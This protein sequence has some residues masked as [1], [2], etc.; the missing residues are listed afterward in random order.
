MCR[1]LGWVARDGLSLRDVLGEESFVAFAQLSR[2][3]ADGWGLAYATGE[4]LEV[5][6]STTNA[7]SDP[8][9]AKVAT[10][11]SSRAGLAHLRWASPGLPVELC[12]AHPFRY[13]DGVGDWAFAHNGGVYPFERVG[14]LL[15]DEWRARLTGTT[16]SEHYFL[17]L[18]AEM[19]ESGDDLPT[20]LPRVLRRI[21]EHYTPS[22]LNAMI[23]GREA[24]YV[25][26][27][28][29]ASI[30][31]E[32]PP[33]E[34]QSVD[35]LVEATEEEAPY[36]DLRY[37]CSG[38]AV[39]VASSGFAQPEGGGWRRIGNNSLLI[40][41]RAT[42]ETTEIPLDVEIRPAAAVESAGADLR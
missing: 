39:V 4:D 27:C 32:L 28:H 40:V 19:T 1:L 30:R 21:T 22:S 23:L 42:L 2:I 5:E 6:R 38:D 17:A 37:R 29:N 34:E 31:P 3:H 16:D 10:A 15:D 11:A 33:L 7:A 9:F 25:V 12:N 36:Y 26:N 13:A 8:A 41:D 35:D 20:A 24:L 18:M 14:D